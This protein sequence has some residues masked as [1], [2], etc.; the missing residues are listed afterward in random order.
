MKPSLVFTIISTGL[1][2]G[3]VKAGCNEQHYNNGHLAWYCLD[4]ITQIPFEHLDLRDRYGE[5]SQKLETE[6]ANRVYK[7]YMNLAYPDHDCHS[8]KHSVDYGKVI[9][10]DHGDMPQETYQTQ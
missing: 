5:A 4:E 6:L 3:L 7:D 1:L 9:F 8:D 10:V 2:S